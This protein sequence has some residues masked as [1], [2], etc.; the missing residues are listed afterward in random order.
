MD[1]PLTLKEK[2]CRIGDCPTFVLAHND[3]STVRVDGEQIME[4]SCRFDLPGWET[5]PAGQLRYVNRTYLDGIP[6]RLEYF[7]TILPE[8]STWDFS[9]RRMTTGH[10]GDPSPT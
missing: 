4:G 1:N 2:N 5:P 10:H 3:G 6:V 8:T 7:P 9:H